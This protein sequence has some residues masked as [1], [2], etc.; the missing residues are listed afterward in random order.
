MS[1]Q[2]IITRPSGR[3]LAVIVLEPKY[4]MRIQYLLNCKMSDKKECPQSKK[5]PKVK[6]PGG[7]VKKEL[8]LF[9]FYLLDSALSRGLA[10]HPKIPIVNGVKL[11]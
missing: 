10:V 3:R 7:R 1:R 9:V 2:V 6:K 8:S 11:K 4:N 5:A